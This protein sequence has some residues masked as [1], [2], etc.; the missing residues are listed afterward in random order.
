MT[1][2]TFEAQVKLTG[3]EEATTGL[4][5]MTDAAHRASLGM[6]PLQQQT[7]AAGLTLDKVEKSLGLTAKAA[8]EK[9]AADKAAAAAAK[10][11]DAA[12][13]KQE[14][15]IRAATTSIRSFMTAI[16]VTA[17]ISGAVKGISSYA[18]E[19]GRADLMLKASLTTSGQYA[20]ASA[21]I[22][23]AAAGNATAITALT[24]AVSY[25]RTE[26]A[27]ANVASTTW[28]TALNSARNAM[29]LSGATTKEAATGIREL[30]TAMADG[31][32]T[33]EEFRKIAAQFPALAQQLASSMGMS[34][35]TM[36]QLGISTANATRA[37]QQNAEAN[38]QAVAG[39]QTVS[40]ATERLSTEFYK[41]VDS[42]DAKYKISEKLVS[43]LDFLG[44]NMETIITIVATA[45]GGYAIWTA[46]SYALAAAKVVLEGA[47]IAVTIAARGLAA[48]IAVMRGPAG[49]AA[50]TAAVVA[51]SIAVNQMAGETKTA[52][53]E[54]ARNNTEN[55]KTAGTANNAAAGLNNQAK[56]Y[57]NVAASASKAASAKNAANNAGGGGGGGG[58]GNS[59]LYQNQNQTYRPNTNNN[60]NPQEEQ[61]LRQAKQAAE[62][63]AYDDR[64][65]SLK[66]Y[67][68][69]TGAKY[70]DVK[71][72]ANPDPFI[73]SKG[74]IK[75]N[76]SG[77]PSSGFGSYGGASSSFG[78]AGEAISGFRAD[79]GPVKAGKRYVVGEEGPE[80]FVPGRSGTILATGAS[81]AAVGGGGAVSRVSSIELIADGVL[82]GLGP[83][84]LKSQETLDKILVQLTPAS[85]AGSIGTPTVGDPSPFANAS[86]INNFGAAPIAAVAGTGNGVGSG[87]GAAAGPRLPASNGA[88][89]AIATSAADT[90]TGGQVVAWAKTYADLVNKASR[91]PPGSTGV[92]SPQEKKR[93]ELMV[94]ASNFLNSLPSGAVDF[95]KAQ[96]GPQM[97]GASGGQVS[98]RNGGSMTIG[99]S[100]A[101][102]SRFVG[103][104]VSP[105]EQIDVRTRRQVREDERKEL[106]I[107]N[108]PITVI[109]D[110]KTPDADSFRKSEKQMSRQFVSTLIK[111]ARG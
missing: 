95:V 34:V 72:M 54:I 91:I 53:Q 15:S 6:K 69:S 4:D 101:P 38:N 71:G 50:L 63:K 7:Q 37:L 20:A 57:D 87:G 19:V 107:G 9:E 45:A 40:A 111:Q 8:K 35:Q 98:F 89:S 106:G 29:M 17:A 25:L 64:Q 88:A 93:V 26:Y 103:M 12:V 66:A 52:T 86:A 49:V 108:A 43:V 5:K 83:I 97:P 76:T 61:A 18:D 22:R 65:A 82:A 109:F 44:R 96:A 100:G 14:A 33:G 67:V 10:E 2:E 110:V 75:V 73:S 23:T 102:D 81:G 46:A 28:V 24:Q 79:G 48:I 56:A 94:Q 105:K 47:I 85:G 78:G 58:G 55:S 59:Q 41:A 11:H 21:A 27:T 62:Q 16:G 70:Y 32:I 51:A 99:G 84:L 90:F 36:G 1:T 68:E 80:L 39:I 92:N 42:I 30:A 3:V 74:N 60:Y 13:R 104:R 77:G 31:T